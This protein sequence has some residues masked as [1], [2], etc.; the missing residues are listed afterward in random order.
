M[1][2]GCQSR[3]LIEW[4][5]RFG[6]LPIIRGGAA[7]DEDEALDAYINHLIACVEDE[8]AVEKPQLKNETEGQPV[9]E[10]EENREKIQEGKDGQQD[11]LEDHRP[12]DSKKDTADE[13]DDDVSQEND[14]I[15]EFSAVVVDDLITKDV[16]VEAAVDTFEVDKAVHFHH[17]EQE[18]KAGLDNNPIKKKKPKPIP[19]ETLTIPEDKTI[20]DSLSG[21]IAD[22]TKEVSIPPRPP[23]AAIRFLLNQG[24]IG[25]IIA[26]ICIWISEFTQAYLPPVANLFAWIFSLLFPARNNGPYVP[27]KNVNEQ[28]AGFVSAD[29]TS[30]RAKKT[31]MATKKA[32]LKAVTQLRRIG[33]IKEAKYRHVSLKFMK[34]YVSFA[35]NARATV[36]VYLTISETGI[37][38]A[39]MPTLRAIKP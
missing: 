20:T 13:Y 17:V 22:A 4:Q 10:V 2:I 21:P 29:G 26:M 38:S 37:K 16:T 11:L 5:W 32:D 33:S 12:R 39:S 35:K 19:P 8:D 27:P 18:R 30:G 36:A 3:P 23:N 6:F 9:E 24:R 7:I 31:K 34:R 1:T 28:Y 15:D 14:K 25:H